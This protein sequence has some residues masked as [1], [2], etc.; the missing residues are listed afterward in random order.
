MGF[1]D[2]A[3]PNQ[4]SMGAT[5]RTFLRT[6]NFPSCSLAS[7][8]HWN[9]PCSSVRLLAGFTS[10][11]KQLSKPCSRQNIMKDS[12]I[13]AFHLSTTDLFLFVSTLIET[14]NIM[15][16][17]GINLNR[18]IPRR[19]GSH[20]EPINKLKWK[21]LYL[22]DED[23][24]VIINAWMPSPPAPGWSKKARSCWWDFSLPINQYP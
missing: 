6:V 14:K 1:R 16:M 10:G 12:P 11:I 24:I 23:F 17:V 8:L 22:N 18:E 13:P 19:M 4:S 15:S 5:R 21:K 2:V 9:G 20:Y 3:I 7:C